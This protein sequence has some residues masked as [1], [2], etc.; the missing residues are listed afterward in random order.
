M[1]LV[2]MWKIWGKDDCLDNKIYVN[3]LKVQK[4]DQH[5]QSSDDSIN[6]WLPNVERK[7]IVFDIRLTYFKFSL[8]SDVQHNVLEAER[9][10]ESTR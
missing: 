7:K 3:S 1:F 4:T 8:K 2:H 6:L 9:L 10:G 5:T